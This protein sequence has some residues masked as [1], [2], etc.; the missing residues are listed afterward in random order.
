V[1]WGPGRSMNQRLYLRRRTA[2]PDRKRR[3]SRSSSSASRFRSA[4]SS[5]TADSS[6]VPASPMSAW[7]AARRVSTRSAPS[8]SS[9]ILTSSPAC[10][11]RRRR[12]SAGRTNRPRASSRAVPRMGVMWDKD[13]ASHKWARRG[14]TRATRRSMKTAPRDKNAD[15][16][17][18][19]LPDASCETARAIGTRKSPAERGFYSAPGEIRTPDLRFR[20]PTLY[21]AE[22]RALTGPTNADHRSVP[23]FQGGPGDPANRYARTGRVDGPTVSASHLTSGRA[24]RSWVRI[25]SSHAGSWSHGSSAWRQLTVSSRRRR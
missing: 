20:R 2:L 13:I 7:A 4:V 19:Q 15:R 10:K 18:T 11:P 25:R 9:L 8:V 12:S 5:S 22:L 6:A 3:A 14:Q 21:P 1:S 17:P 23:S 24:D 16:C